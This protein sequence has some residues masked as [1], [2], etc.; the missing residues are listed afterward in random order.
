MSLLSTPPQLVLSAGHH[1]GAAGA[2]F[3]DIVEWPLTKVWVTE[4]VSNFSIGAPVLI[5][6]NDLLSRKIKTINALNPVPK[7]CLEVHFNSSPHGGAGSE[8]LYTPGSL[9]SKLI[10]EKIQVVLSK[11]S[12]PDRGIKEGWYKQDLERRVPDAFLSQTKPV[13]VILEPFFVQQVSQLKDTDL[14]KRMCKEL[15]D[16]L[17][18]EY[19]LT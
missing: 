4:L 12:K 2:S 11:F 7:L 5:I 15:A 18:V 9:R 1:E 19:G 13:A 16:L 14:R 17:K 6:T 8:T 3:Q 10:A